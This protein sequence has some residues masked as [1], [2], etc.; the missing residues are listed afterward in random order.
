MINYETTYHGPILSA[1]GSGVSATESIDQP[2]SFF[3]N[4]LSMNPKTG[5]L[6]FEVHEDS[7]VRGRVPLPNARITVSRP[8]GGGFY[9]SKIVE[10]DENGETGPIPLPTVSRDLSL[11]PG[12]GQVSTSYHASVELPGY[13]RQD[14]YDIQIFDGITTVQ[15]V[16]LQPSGAR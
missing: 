12:G 13:I 14:L 15:H 5:Y 6:T 1:F 2:Y 11:R 9:F 4:F 10:T 3:T 8:L 16:A 7:P